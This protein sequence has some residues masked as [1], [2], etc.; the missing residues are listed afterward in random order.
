MTSERVK[1]FSRPPAE[2]MPE[3]PPAGT[4][5]DGTYRVERV[6]GRGGMG[7][8]LKALDLKLER[9]VAIKLISRAASSR[10]GAHD[11][12]ITEARAMAGVRH[13][14][15]AQ[16]YSFGEYA[17]VP[18]FAMEYV[19]GSTLLHRMLQHDQDGLVAPVD[20]V[21]G[22]IEQVCRGLRAIHDA[23]IIHG[24]IKP[25]NVLLG[26]AFRAVVTDFGLMRWRGQAESTD[27]VIGTPAYI[28][29]EVVHA[30]DATLTLTR[31][32]DVFSLGVTAY[33]MLTGRLPFL[34]QDIADLFDVHEAGTRAPP[35]S[36]WR[37]DLPA[38]FDEVFLKAVEPDPAK[39]YESAEQFRRAVVA[40]RAQVATPA[41]SVRIVVAD[42]DPDFSRFVEATLSRAFPG[43]ELIAVGDGAAALAHLERRAAS[44]AVIDLDMP[45]MN[46]VE[47]TAALR[48]TEDGRR[49]PILVVTGSG[50]AHDWELL[51]QLGADGFLV[52]PADPY[53]LVAV[54]QRMVELGQR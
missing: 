41:R 53:A 28:P 25:G 30:E 35:P 26:P 48:A 15:V 9:D 21:I 49:T 2:P 1:R 52:K 6:V 5:L 22:V 29:P 47:L 12:F 32:A 54:A 34:I 39:R 4:I 42:D 10:P 38:A 51:N 37:D 19:P 23:G 43:C 3:V 17:G 31:G 36:E 50:G 8:V 27:T 46:G 7:V 11:R 18:Y 20:E 44:L 13:E 45:G 40:A 33:E 24:D 14:N 16:I